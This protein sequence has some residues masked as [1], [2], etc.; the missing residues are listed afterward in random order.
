MVTNANLGVMNGGRTEGAVQETALREFL[1]RLDLGSSAD[2]VHDTMVEGIQQGWIPPGTKL[3]EVYL[4]QVFYVSRTPVREALLRLESEGL[5]VRDK[6]RGLTV[7]RVTVEQIMEIYVLREAFDGTAARLAA[8]SAQALDL[9]E[10]SQ[11]NAELSE[12]ASSGRYTEMTDLN[13]EFHLVLARASRNGML[14][15]FTEQLYGYVRRFQTT[16]FT[17]P[18]RAIVAVDEHRDLVDALRAHDAERAEHIARKHMREALDVR[19][20]LEIDRGRPGQ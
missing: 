8:S 9:E 13:I 2:A 7:A 15:Q 18:G 5:V 6:H 16:T 12:M 17:Y 11:I 4:T 19:I 14:L 10:L 20:R 1:E 3:G